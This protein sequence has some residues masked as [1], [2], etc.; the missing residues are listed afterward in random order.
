MD[1]QGLYNKIAKRLGVERSIIMVQPYTGQ[2]MNPRAE[3]FYPF[4]L[5]EF[6]SIVWTKM[7]GGRKQG[8]VTLTLHVGHQI[9][10]DADAFSVVHQKV[11]R[12]LDGFFPDNTESTAMRHTSD[13]Q[14]TYA[15]QG[16][17]V[18]K[19]TF[20]VMIE[21]NTKAWQEVPVQIEAKVRVKK[22]EQ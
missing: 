15:E 14:D 4:V 16:L 17:Y 19:S 11:V 3:V 21:E 9:S 1:I 22:R 20:E 8:E 2:Y 10:D 12:L 5:V 6:S 18:W 7:Q 13:M